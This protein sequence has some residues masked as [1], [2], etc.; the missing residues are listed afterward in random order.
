MRRAAA[1]FLLFA[2]MLTACGPGTS[3]TFH[4]DTGQTFTVRTEKAR[5]VG[6]EEGDVGGTP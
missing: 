4:T 5:P 2:L 3:R 1:V 6:V